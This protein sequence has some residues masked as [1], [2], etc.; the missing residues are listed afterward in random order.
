MSG[1]AE[2][3]KAIFHPPP[4]QLSCPVRFV[5]YSDGLGV[6]AL[7]SR[8]S[9]VK[10]IYTVKCERAHIIARDFVLQAAN[11]TKFAKFGSQIL[12]SEVH[13]FRAA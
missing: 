6:P 5:R 8:H 4:S 9:A 11:V 10:L 12:N 7:V 1:A 3:P 2:F 13:T